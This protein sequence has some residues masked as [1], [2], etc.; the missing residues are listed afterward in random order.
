MAGSKEL[1]DNA[2]FLEVGID[3][4]WSMLQLSCNTE[5]HDYLDLR[6]R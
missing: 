3:D 5:Q 6:G 2:W 1:L 4:E